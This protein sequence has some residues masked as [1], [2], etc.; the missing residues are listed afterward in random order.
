MVLFFIPLHLNAAYK[1]GAL[2]EREIIAGRLPANRERWELTANVW[3]QAKEWDKAL[4]ALEKVAAKSEDGHNHVR[5]TRHHIEREAWN[6]V[7]LQF[8]H[9]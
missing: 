3:Q 2:L 4:A 8:Y 5:L 9:S 1:A 6:V 7:T